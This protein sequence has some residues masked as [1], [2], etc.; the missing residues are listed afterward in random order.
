MSHESVWTLALGHLGH[1]GEVVSDWENPD[2]NAQNVLAIFYSTARELALGLH[3][4]AFARKRHR[5]ANVTATKPPSP[6]WQF[7]WTMP[8][9]I[10]A[11]RGFT[12]ERPTRRGI[13]RIAYEIVQDIVDPTAKVMYTN[14]DPFLSSD[15][16]IYTRRLTNAEDTL[17]TVQFE[18]VLAAVLAAEASLSLGKDLTFQQR[19]YEF[20]TVRALQGQEIE[21]RNDQGIRQISSIESVRD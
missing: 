5:P 15:Y 8:T 16:M 9:D 17:F 19:M 13:D 12:I 6:E 1:T 21:V 7:T 11:M 18:A 20:A 14:V 3:D 10:I 4:W 2:S